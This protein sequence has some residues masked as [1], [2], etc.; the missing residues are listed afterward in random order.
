MAERNSSLPKFRSAVFVPPK[1][2]P[3]P[4]ERAR[5]AGLL[6]EITGERNPITTEQLATAILTALEPE[7][8]RLNRVSALLQ[9]ARLGVPEGIEGARR[10]LTNPVLHDPVSAQLV[11]TAF[12]P[13]E[14]QDPGPGSPEWDGDLALRALDAFKMRS[15]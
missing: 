1:E 3:D 9:G 5:V 14:F 7:K 15:A 8:E 13:T 4:E 10:I 6:D 2:G 11:A 12:N